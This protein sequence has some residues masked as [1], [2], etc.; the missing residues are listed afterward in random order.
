MPFSFS[1][2][3]KLALVKEVH[4]VLKQ[5]ALLPCDITSSVKGDSVILVVWYKDEM[6]PIY[7]LKHT[8]KLFL[9]KTFLN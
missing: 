3:E 5:T 9:K 2:Y 6:T 4:A 7:S 1:F 8:Q